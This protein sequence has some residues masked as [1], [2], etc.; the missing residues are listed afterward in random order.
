[1]VAVALIALVGFMFKLAVDN[2]F[3]T[4]W[5]GAGTIVGVLTGAV[6]S[7]FF[8]T[9]ADKA[10][11]RAEAISAEA[12]SEAVRAARERAPRAFA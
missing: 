12:P 5:A 7:Y 10:A 8:K 2:D 6:P 3:A 4:I 11:A 9:Q 1:M